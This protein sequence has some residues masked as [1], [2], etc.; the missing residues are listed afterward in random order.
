MPPYPTLLLFGYDS[1]RPLQGLPTFSTSS[2][3]GNFN[4][5]SDYNFHSLLQKQ[6]CSRNRLC[7][8]AAERLILIFWKTFKDADRIDLFD[9]ITRGN[10][11]EKLYLQLK[12]LFLVV[13]D[14]G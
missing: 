12:S 14:A 7:L 3:Y 4:V 11:F 2:I 13:L 1:S 10:F 6:S 8:I 5:A 9:F